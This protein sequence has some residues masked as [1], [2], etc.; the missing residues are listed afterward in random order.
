L[1]I[2]VFSLV[3]HGL[4][5]FNFHIPANMLLFSVYAGLIMAPAKEDI[6]SHV[7]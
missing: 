6:N 2:G 4:T 7:K 1:A 5:D 3:L